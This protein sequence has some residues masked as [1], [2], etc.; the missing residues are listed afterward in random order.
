MVV[1]LIDRF[2]SLEQKAV[3]GQDGLILFVDPSLDSQS[4]PHTVT[5]QEI[6]SA[7][8]M[9]SYSLHSPPSLPVPKYSRPFL[10]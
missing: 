3:P 6:K 9:L 5:M 1:R 7:I 2:S 4:I 8:E 10:F